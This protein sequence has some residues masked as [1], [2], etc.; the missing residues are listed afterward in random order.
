MLYPM[1]LEDDRE[2]ERYQSN[3]SLLS[4]NRRNNIHNSGGIS[5]FLNFPFGKVYAEWYG[6]TKRRDRTDVWLPTGGAFTCDKAI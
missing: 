4:F 2:I 5:D 1:N 6:A 3:E